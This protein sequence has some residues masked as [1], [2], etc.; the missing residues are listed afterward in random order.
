MGGV[1]I[2]QKPCV[3]ESLMRCM[4]YGLAQVLRRYAHVLVFLQNLQV[5][6]PPAIALVP[7]A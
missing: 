4:L 1:K 6:P 7:F 3:V 2:K 5:C